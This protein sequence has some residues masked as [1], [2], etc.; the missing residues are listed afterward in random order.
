MDSISRYK[1]MLTC[2]CA[3]YQNDHGCFS[4]IVAQTSIVRA[5]CG[6]I[7]LFKPC[8]HAFLWNHRERNAAASHLAGV[9]K[10]VETPTR[11]TY[12]PI[13]KFGTHDIFSRTKNKGS[14]SK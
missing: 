9:V 13:S 3:L 12:Y 11:S 5:G 7:F 6:E 1:W 8:K 2:S 10:I 4:L 14:R